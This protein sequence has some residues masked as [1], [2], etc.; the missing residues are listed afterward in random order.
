MTGGE[1]GLFGKE[2]APTDYDQMLNTITDMGGV[3]LENGAEIYRV[4]ESMRRLCQ[5]YG[6]E[7]GEVFA[8]SSSIFCSFQDE[9]G[10]NYCRMRRITSRTMDLDK[11]ERA[12]ALCRE[13]CA[14]PMAAEEVERRLREIEGGKRYSFPARLGSSVLVAAAFTLLFGGGWLDAVLAGVCG[15]AIR[16]GLSFMEKRKSNFFF[17]NLAVSALAAALALTAFRLGM[18]VHTD[19]VI[20]GALMLL[21]PGVALTN[22]MR[23]LMAEDFISGMLK[24]TEALLVAAAIALGTGVAV[25]LLRIPG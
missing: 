24:L 20:I 16:L 21:V 1:R 17:T 13:V 19:K 3:L 2:A 25:W 23:D 11:V 22:F 6:L 9:N 5:A 4:E 7:T 18:P 14:G 10:H 8:I 15:G 12:N